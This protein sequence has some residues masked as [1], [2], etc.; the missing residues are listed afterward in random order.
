MESHFDIRVW[1]TVSQEYRVQEVFE[2]LLGSMNQLNVKMDDQLA[3][4]LYKTLKDLRYLVVID[5][6]WDTKFWNQ[7]RRF[8]PNDKNGS[9]II[10]T[11]R[12]VE[13]A[14]AAN[15]SSL[16]HQ[17]PLLDSENSWKL[18]CEKVFA[19]GVCP[20]NFIEIGKEISN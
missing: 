20:E 9:R 14:E 3:Y 19:D 8:F 4:C 5:D 6:M 2:G 10:L 16:L 7:V 18:L 11:T 15:T 13:V 1:V 12:I 17:M